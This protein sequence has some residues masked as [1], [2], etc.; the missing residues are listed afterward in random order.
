M[1]AQGVAD[2]VCCVVQSPDVQ[3][4]EPDPLQV[5]VEKVEGGLLGDAEMIEVPL[6]G[7]DGECESVCV[8]A[9]SLYYF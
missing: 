3:L 7:E 8:R 6:I 5:K 9:L 1:P 2:H 4:V